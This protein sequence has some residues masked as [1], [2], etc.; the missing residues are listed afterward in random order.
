MR[1]PGI[2]PGF[3]IFAASDQRC[4]RTTADDAGNIPQPRVKSRIAAMSCKAGD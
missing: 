3:F 4:C 2:A 1:K